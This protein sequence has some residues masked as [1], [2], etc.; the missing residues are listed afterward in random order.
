MSIQKMSGPRSVY[1]ILIISILCNAPLFL[2][3]FNAFE[4]TNRL[5]NFKI[6]LFVRELIILR[7]VVGY[8]YK[9][10][11]YCTVL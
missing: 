8:I 4:N 10:F 7:I 9:K 3:D 6:E 1:C 2:Q 5:A 11:H